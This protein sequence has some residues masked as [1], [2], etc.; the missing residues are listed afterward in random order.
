M[1]NHIPK[2]INLERRRKQDKFHE[3]LSLKITCLTRC[4]AFQTHWGG[5]PAFQTQE[6]LPQQLCQ[7]GVPRPLLGGPISWRW[8]VLFPHGFEQRASGL[9]KVRWWILCLK[10]RRQPWSW[11]LLWSPFFFCLEEQ[12]TFFSRTNLWSWIVR[13]KKSDIFINLFSHLLLLQPN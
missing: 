2:W 5:S 12:G 10:L 11:I 4:F 8:V 6:V 9:L 13:S 1:D 7:A 3:I